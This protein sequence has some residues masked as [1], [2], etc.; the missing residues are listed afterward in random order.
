[1]QRKFRHITYSDRILLEI[2]LKD[3]KKIADIAK[4]MGFHIRT[5]YKEIKR[6]E[7]LHRNMDYT[8]EHR[9]SADK[10]QIRADEMKKKH[11]AELKIGKDIKLA[12]YIE[13]LIYKHKY[14]PKTALQK[15][16]NDN[17]SNFSVEIK[18]PNTIYS[19][20]QKGIF[21]KLEMKHLPQGNKRKKKTVVEK[22]GRKQQ[23]TS[24]E[25][26]PNEIYDRLSFGHWEMDCVEGSKSSKKTLLVLTERKSRYE[27]IEVLKRHTLDQ[28]VK[29]LNRIETRFGASFYK[30]FKTITVDNGS[31]FANQYLLEKAVRRKNNRC[32][33]YYCHPYCSSERGSNENA[34]KLIRRWFPKGSNFDEI[35][36]TKKAKAVEE[37]MNNYPRE[38]LNWKTSK[39]IYLIEK[40]KLFKD[41]G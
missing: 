13:E 16:K 34:N 30:I 33:V 4:E 10:A 11:G 27:I 28:V 32:K 1:M 6:G 37:W 26:R 22:K 5:I 41:T 31:E 20:I 35:I 8:H 2:R 25:E 14:S 7:Y 39:E 36:T 24:I 18:S 40:E 21:L 17:R 9:Y 19:Y 12:N 29:A 23:G 3:G 38:I 15:I